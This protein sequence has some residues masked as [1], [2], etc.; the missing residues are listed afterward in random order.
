VDNGAQKLSTGLAKI[1]NTTRKV[2]NAQKAHKEKPN[3]SAFKALFIADPDRASADSVELAAM[4]AQ[5]DQKLVQEITSRKL[6]FTDKLI[7][8]LSTHPN[9][10]K[11]L[12]ALQE[13]S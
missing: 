4:E 8:A 12:R 3:S 11:R 5:S 13:L 1:V 7:E 9:I 10:V 6:T 2:N